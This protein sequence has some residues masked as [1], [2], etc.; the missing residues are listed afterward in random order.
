MA[1]G[2][3]KLFM[4]DTGDHFAF[5]AEGVGTLRIEGNNIYK[6]VK[7]VTPLTDSVGPQVGSVANYL[8]GYDNN[9]VSGSWSELGRVAPAGVYLWS[10]TAAAGETYGWLQLTGPCIVRGLAITWF[11]GVAAKVDNAGV[12]G[13]SNLRAIPMAGA[14][15]DHPLVGTRVD[16]VTYSVEVSTGST[17]AVKLAL[18]F[19]I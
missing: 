17:D 10:S 15:Y 1:E 19:P 4:T 12:E 3:K 16:N 7:N 2:L 6:W 5:D 11:P 9:V 18:R 14:D 8:P 13:L